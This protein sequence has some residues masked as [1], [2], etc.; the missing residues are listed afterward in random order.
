MPSVPL[1]YASLEEVSRSIRRKEVSSAEVTA[2]V[3]GRIREHNGRLNAFLEMFEDEA[4]VAARRADRALARGKWLGPLH[5]VP[6]S[7]K[8]L[9]DVKGKRTSAGSRTTEGDIAASDSAVTERLL[10]A[11]AII[12]GKANMSEFACGRIYSGYGPLANPWDL[13]KFAGGSSSGSGAS[14]AAGMG[15]AS[16]G[17]DTGGSIRLPAA[18]SGTVGLKPTYGRVSRRGV[19]TLSW[20]LDHAGPL[21][22]TARDAAIVLQAIAGY[23]AADPASSAAPVPNYLRG[24]PSDLRGLT[25]GIP[26]ETYYESLDPEVE[27]AMQEAH[28]ALRRLGARLKRVRIPHAGY[29]LTATIAIMMAEAAAFHAS[30]LRGRFHLLTDYVASR[31]LEGALTPATHYIRAQRIRT[32]LCH[33]TQQA[34]A[35]VDALLL[36]TVPIPAHSLDPSVASPQFL[37]TIGRNTSIGNI[38]G[39][40]ALS[41]PCGFTPGGLPIGMQLLGRGFDERTLIAIAAAYQQATD[42]HLR[43]PALFP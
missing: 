14:I 35:G 16:L 38:T 25:I 3:L 19:F 5:G 33:E 36:P 29:G 8:D 40:P 4:M 27:R 31:L 37:A 15:Y 34:L 43:H 1:H 30:R 26:W 39:L 21:T 12:I 24:L 23:D 11:G 2:L 32:L 42:F 20:S 28:R 22:R 17:S 9:F 10:H 13:A 41:L 18:F 6:I 7:L